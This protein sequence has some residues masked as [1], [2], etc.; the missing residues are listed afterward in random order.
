[1]L[2][3]N[4]SQRL[5]RIEAVAVMMG[6]DILCSHPWI[7]LLLPHL[8][9]DSARGGGPLCSD[10]REMVWLGSKVWLF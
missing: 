4:L 8:G 3:T 6:R 5:I 9:C 10:G 7:L 2:R 1:M